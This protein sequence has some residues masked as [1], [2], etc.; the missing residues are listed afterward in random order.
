[1]YFL[2]ALRCVYCA[3]C[4]SLVSQTAFEFVQLLNLLFFLIACYHYMLQFCAHRSFNLIYV[5]V[6]NFIRHPTNFNFR[7]QVTDLADIAIV[8]C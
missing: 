4:I 1:M 3:H 8:S 6:I 7:I 5:P 2:L